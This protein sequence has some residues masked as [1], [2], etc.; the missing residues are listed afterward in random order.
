VLEAIYQS[1][2]CAVAVDDKEVLHE[3]QQLARQ[4]GLFIC[5]E[6]AAT[7]A[8]S[9]QLKESG[10]LG[11]AELVVAI[12]TGTGLK[13]PETVEVSVPTLQPEDSLSASGVRV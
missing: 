10:W 6:G 4:E 1:G 12:N 13:Y 5:P 9:R 8:A 11:E 3:Q 7:L 2:G